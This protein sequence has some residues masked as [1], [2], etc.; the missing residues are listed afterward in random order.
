MSI[1]SNMRIIFLLSPCKLRYFTYH[2]I[3]RKRKY[4]YSLFLIF[5]YSRNTGR[6]GSEISSGIAPLMIVSTF[7]KQYLS[8]FDSLWKNGKDF[9]DV[10]DTILRTLAT[11]CEDD[12]PE[13]VYYVALYELFGELLKDISDDDYSAN[14]R[15][16]FKNSVIWNKL[17]DF[18]RDAALAIINK[19]ERYNGC[20]DNE[21]EEHP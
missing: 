18:Q 4:H 17:Y 7:S 2:H 9:I 16:G 12:S 13:Y 20:R 5:I 21:S 3:S 1:A 11:L 14:E 19:L 15:V 10:K 6:I 8:L